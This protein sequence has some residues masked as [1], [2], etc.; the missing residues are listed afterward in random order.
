MQRFFPFSRAVLAL[1]ALLAARVAF[2]AATEI[3]KGFTH[4]RTEGDI[5]EYRLDTNGLTVLLLPDHSAPAVTMMVTYRVGSRNE[6]YGT[7]GSTHLLEHLMFKGTKEHNKE[8]GT[9]YDQL[10]E[11]TGAITNATTSQDRTNYYQ[12]VGSQDLP[13]A[14]ELEADRMRNLRLR[15]EDRRPE[16]TVVRNE[17]EIG[18]NNPSEALEKEMWAVAYLAHPYHHS[19]IGW[20][21]DFEKVPIEKLRSFYDTFYWPDNATVTI[22]GDFQTPAA[23]ELIKKYYGSIPKSPHPIPQVY[24]EEPP[25]TGPR[26]VVVQRPGELGVVM[27]AQKIPPGRDRDYA[28]LRVL[29]MILADGR[30]SR[31]YQALTDK[32]LTTNVDAEPE[33]NRDPSLFFITA[34]LAPGATH[35]DVEKRLL[36]ELKH[37]QND[38]VKPEEVAAA[39]AKYT[40]DTAY[41][42]D[43][44]MAMAFALNECIASGDWALYYRLAEDVKK[45]T[46]EDV[47]RVANKYF[48]ED[49]R[50]TGWY[51]PREDKAAAASEENPSQSTADVNAADDHPS[52]HDHDGNKAKAASEGSAKSHN[53][54]AA[55]KSKAVPTS[56]APVAL[57]APRI[58]R[59][60]VDGID[61]LI[62]PTGV[63]D[64]VTIKGTFF[65]FD[66][67]N[68]ILGEL[69]AEML[70]RG[71]EKHDAEAIATE[72]DKIGAKI[73]FASESGTIKFEARCLKKDS[74]QVIN[75]L[76]E[77]LREPNFP[78]DEFE[79]LRKQEIA[80]SQQMKDDPGSQA[81][82]ALRRAIFQSGHPQY[83]LTAEERI[84][85]LEKA[86][87]DD[88]KAFHKKYFGPAYCAMVVVGDMQ[89]GSI[90]KQVKSAFDGWKGGQPLPELPGLK[91]ISKAEDL[92]VAIPGKESVMVFFGE[93]TDLHYAD[94]DYLPLSV[95]TNVLG[96]GF[97]SRLLSTVRD[98]EGLT[99][100][101]TAQLSGP[102][103]L[104]QTWIVYGS[105]APSLLKQG[106]A[107]THRELAKWYHDGI[108]AAELDYRKDSLVGGHRVKLS[109]SGDLAEVILE[110][111][112]RGLDLSWID[113]YP[114]KV[115][116][117]SLDQVNGVIQKHLNPNKLVTAEAGTF[118][119]E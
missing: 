28:A 74:A 44:S 63:K 43:G 105:F 56:A 109:T 98:T 86:E 50:T 53:A 92:K 24:T 36:A 113:E 111:V 40:A 114:K 47:K 77:E 117:L 39:I 99:Y 55:S 89:P 67:K 85:A 57:I 49:E 12:T 42:R 79:K 101:M 83:R 68:P 59:S 69:A 16:M 95:A 62:C 17:Y 104:D 38:G 31:Y 6:S 4:V 91:D 23:L 103:K 115:Q 66:P 87:L 33:F 30:N 52:A 78:K 110:T 1:L 26:R 118:K 25:Q 60:K 48:S 20:H 75:L 2:A 112:E 19:T 102:G 37:V 84:A 29:G 21:S 51:V 108:T 107:S 5:S 46:A 41:S 88:V 119:S 71:T 70:E 61:L 65:A 80:E 10:L 96:Y 94:A 116:A 64:V 45:V 58:N 27:I 76:A 14:V 81:M 32:N 34:E 9:G 106:L 72:L 15:E 35:E 7:T 100:G 3:P 54:L 18:E 97:T 82:I 90:E 13:L 73:D 22:I 8:A 11:R 93:P